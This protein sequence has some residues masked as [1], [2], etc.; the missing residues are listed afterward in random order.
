MGPQSKGESRTQK[1]QTIEHYKA[2]YW[3]P[4]N[5]LYAV[6]LVLEFQDDL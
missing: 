2:G 1:K 4:K 6:L 3:T 5:S